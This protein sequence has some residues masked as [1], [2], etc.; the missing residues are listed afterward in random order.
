MCQ[1]GIVNLR[2]WFAHTERWIAAAMVAEFGD[3]A[4]GDLID[5]LSPITKVDRVR[6]PTLV[7][8]GANDTNCPV[9]EAQQMVAAISTRGVPVELILFPD[10]G[11]GFALPANRARAVLETA[12]WFEQYLAASSRARSTFTPTG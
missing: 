9:E 11:H 3:P 4:D 5:R 8:H 7:I 10:E 2:T 12:R 1:Y 6:T